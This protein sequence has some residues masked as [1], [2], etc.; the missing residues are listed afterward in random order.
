MDTRIPFSVDESKH[1]VAFFPAVLAGEPAGLLGKEGH[2]EEDPDGGDYLVAPWDA[3]GGCV[4]V[5][6]VGRR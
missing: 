4:V 2:G 3:K 6:G 1:G 5:V